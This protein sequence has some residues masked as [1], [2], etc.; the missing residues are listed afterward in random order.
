MIMDTCKRCKTYCQMLGTATPNSYV[1]SNCSAP[2]NP[3]R[4]G[5]AW[6][7]LEGTIALAAFLI[8]MTAVVLIGLSIAGDVDVLLY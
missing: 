4:R 3:R 6:Y 7:V 8:V 5:L 2:H 1:C